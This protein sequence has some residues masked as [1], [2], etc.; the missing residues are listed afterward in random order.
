MSLPRLIY[1][2]DGNR[3]LYFRALNRFAKIQHTFQGEAETPIFTALRPQ[4]NLDLSN[5]HEGAAKGHDKGGLR[6]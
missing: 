4:S 5:W 6:G 1:T 3:L 2:P